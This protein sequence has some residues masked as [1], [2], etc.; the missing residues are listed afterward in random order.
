[1]L[2]LFWFPLFIS[3]ADKLAFFLKDPRP[4]PLEIERRI[5]GPMRGMEMACGPS[6]LC[7]TTPRPYPL[8]FHYLRTLEYYFREDI[9]VG[10]TYIRR[11]VIIVLA[12]VPFVI[13]RR[14]ISSWTATLERR[15]RQGIY[16]RWTC[17]GCGD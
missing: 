12:S 5:I 3:T 7:T 16:G 1:M 10:A 2:R 15:I 8:T 14:R 4:N 11:R 13:S 9:G 17:V 6:V